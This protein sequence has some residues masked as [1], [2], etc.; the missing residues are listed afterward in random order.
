MSRTCS[1]IHLHLCRIRRLSRLLGSHPID[2]GFVTER[3]LFD[4]TIH[5]C[6]GRYT[7]VSKGKNNG[8][9]GKN[10]R[11]VCPKCGEPF[12]A[13]P[14]VFGEWL[15]LWCRKYP[16]LLPLLS[17]ASTRFVVCDSCHHFFQVLMDVDGSQLANSASEAEEHLLSSLPSPKQVD[18]IIWY[19]SR[20]FYSVALV[21]ILY[22]SYLCARYKNWLSHSCV[23]MK[24]LCV[25]AHTHVIA[26]FDMTDDLAG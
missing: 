13:T 19:S 1:H 20:L 25:Y 3:R 9:G 6:S 21:I 18:Y 16:R 8:L 10:G 24:C 4:R 22:W 11:V 26:F 17:I 14:S 5:T 15:S 23:Y 12:K 7:N 2:R